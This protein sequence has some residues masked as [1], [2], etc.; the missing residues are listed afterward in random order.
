MYKNIMERTVSL[1][2]AFSYILSMFPMTVLAEETDT[3]TVITEIEGTTD[4]DL[5]SKAVYGTNV[6]GS[7]LKFTVTK[8][9]P[10]YFNDDMGFWQKKNDSKWETVYNGTFTDGTWRYM[11]Q[12]RIDGEYGST[13]KLSSDVTVKVDGSAWDTNSV[14]VM[15]SYSY[16]TAYSNEITINNE[17]QTT[18][19]VAYDVNGGTVHG[20]ELTT[21]TVASGDTF[22]ITKLFQL[23]DEDYH[24]TVH[25][26]KDKWFDAFEVSGER[27]E[28]GA[29]ITITGNT[30]IKY[31]W[32]DITYV[33]KVELTID[34]PVAGTKIEGEF[35]FLTYH[36]S[37]IFF[38]RV[39]G[40]QVSL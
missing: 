37:A 23:P 36:Q 40:T 2:L 9:S 8:G 18:Y 10:A 25:P 32:K 24:I 15:D 34:P 35:N 38:T 26:P 13:H 22:T 5:S 4:T 12:L 1:L 19:T 21:R 31:L 11:T 33:D 17:S 16:V 20:G 28:R 3:R 29:K 27:Y 39:H 7:K 14:T 6:V 30:V